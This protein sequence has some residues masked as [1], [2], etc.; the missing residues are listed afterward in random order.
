MLPGELAPKLALGL[1]AEASGER[2]AAAR[3]FGVVW[4]TDRSYVS[5]AFG[6]ARVRLAAGDRAGAV[7]VLAAVPETSSHHVAAQVA[8]IRA[9]I[10][11]PDPAAV[12]A[13]DLTE[14]GARMERLRLDAVVRH[15]LTAEIL[16]AGLAL[17]QRGTGH[18][19][20]PAARLRDDR[21]GAPARPGTELPGPGPALRHPARPVRPGR[22]GQRRPP[23][24]ADL[25]DPGGE[26]GAALAGLG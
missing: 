17:V 6:L 2:D 1:A 16:Q 20:R 25:T 24:D 4:T 5:A 9:R 11:A 26:P 10:T 7:D 22:P 12:S 23:A 15:T 8:A 13:A 3:Y 19:R 21:P 18:G 14:A